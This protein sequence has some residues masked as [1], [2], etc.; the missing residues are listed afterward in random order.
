MIIFIVFHVIL[1]LTVVSDIVIIFNPE[2]L[3]NKR[4][5]LLAARQD[6][7]QPLLFL[8]CTSDC[9]KT[10]FKFSPQ[11]QKSINSGL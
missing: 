7:A 6:S 11:T 3:E 8:S 4:G 5:F 2:D 9:V 1:E 10:K